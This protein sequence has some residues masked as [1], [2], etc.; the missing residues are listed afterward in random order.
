M[1]NNDMKNYKR[2]FIARIL[3]LV[4]LIAVGVGIYNYVKD[5]QSPNGTSTKVT[6]KNF[7]GG[8]FSFSYPSNFEVGNASGILLGEEKQV[9]GVKVS[10]NLPVANCGL[11]GLPEHCTPFTE[12][13]GISMYVV[14]APY[15]KFESN[16]KKGDL[17]D[18]VREVTIAGKK[19]VSVNLGVEGEGQFFYYVPVDANRTLFITRSYIDDSNLISYA[20]NPDFIKLADQEKV[21]NEIVSTLKIK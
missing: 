12:N 17:K 16:L 5:G 20:Q 13:P 18:L 9:R 7:D 14:E 6:Q 8:M 10:H 15:S 3:L 4:V 1:I 11:S 21:F 19:G 2:G